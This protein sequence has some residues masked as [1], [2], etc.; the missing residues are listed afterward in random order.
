MDETIIRSEI[1][2]GIAQVDETLT[3]SDFACIFDKENRKLKVGF[4][5][6]KPTNETVEVN[7]SYG[8]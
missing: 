5:A 2:Q 1:E 4:T 6:K 7:V 3:I 8:N